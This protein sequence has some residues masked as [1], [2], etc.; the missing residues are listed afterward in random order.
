[1]A[2]SQLLAEIYE[3]PRVVAHILER[4]REKVRQVGSAIHTSC[5]VCRSLLASIGP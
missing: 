3:Q 2:E 5:A 1:M 4:Q